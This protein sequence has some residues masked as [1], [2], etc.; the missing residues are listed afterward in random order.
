MARK[1]KLDEQELFLATEKLL[2]KKGYDGFHFKALSE[3]L[4][5]ARS[6]IYEYY[7]NKDDLITSYMMKRMDE[8]MEECFAL[9]VI[10]SPVA[11]LKQLL[12][13]F[14]TRSHTHQVIEMI[15]LLKQ[16]KSL[17]IQQQVDDLTHYHQKMYEFIN[18]IIV[19]AQ[20]EGLIRK[21]IEPPVIA[22]LLFNAIQIVNV[23]NVPPK[24]WSE[25]LFSII[26]YGIHNG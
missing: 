16:A 20:K 25:K 23:M 12:E 8:I 26:F 9:S 13:I 22:S 10:D 17:K 14:I 24:E 4:E 2:V 3:E 5:V 18:E 6:T 19:K 15:P 11:Q 7:A 1:K 21:N